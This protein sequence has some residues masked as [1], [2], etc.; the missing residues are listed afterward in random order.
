MTNLP[1]TVRAA[2]D[3]DL[4]AINAIY[5]AYIVTSHAT[6]DV[7]ERS[8]EWRRAWFEE[9]AS[10]RHHVL[11]CERGD[12]VVGFA[13]SGTHRPRAAYETTVETSVYVSPDALGTGVGTALYRALF[14]ALEGA[15]VHRAVAGITLP[16]EAS[17]ALHLAFGYRPVGRFTDVG[18]KFGRY[19]DVEWYER[20]LG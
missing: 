8:L 12:A 11:V 14:V 17:V 9:H 1:S 6:F 13:S 5:N 2:A 16:N 3:H 19:W 10:E 20:L 4:E 7:E 15:D 18:R